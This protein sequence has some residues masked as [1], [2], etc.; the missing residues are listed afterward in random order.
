MLSI[1][2]ILARLALRPLAALGL[3]VALMAAAPMIMASDSEMT[4]EGSEPNKRFHF[5][6]FHAILFA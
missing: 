5:P 6:G 2:T 1:L 4:D 3:V